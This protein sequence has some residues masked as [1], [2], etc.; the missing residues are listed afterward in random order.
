MKSWITTAMSFHAKSLNHTIHS[1]FVPQVKALMDKIKV[2]GAN[3]LRTA[4]G[5]GSQN[6]TSAPKRTPSEDH[7]RSECCKHP[8]KAWCISCR[9]DS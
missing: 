1:R 4:M 8:A 6:K 7:Q 3:Q 5:G 2:T 9:F